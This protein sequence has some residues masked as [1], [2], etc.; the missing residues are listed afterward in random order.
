MKK[1]AFALS[2]LC[3]ALQSAGLAAQVQQDAVPDE[4][5]NALIVQQQDAAAQQAAA[6]K[7]KEVETIVVVG[8]SSTRQEDITGAAVDVNIAEVEDLSSA[9]IMQNLQ[10]RVPG[11][12][13]LTNGNPNSTAQ[14]KIRGQGLGPL[15]YNDPLYVVDGVPMNSG[16]HE[17]NSND[18]ASLV[19][20][21]DAASASIYGARAANGVIIITTKKGRGDARFEV[22]LNTSTEDFEYDLNPLNTKQRAEAVWRAAVNDGANPNNV[23]P[24][25]QYDWNGDFDNPQLNNVI[26]NTYID[27]A[28]TMRPA[29]TDWFD[30]V[31][32][33]S[34]SK[35]LNLSYSSGS[36]TSSLYASLGY[37]DRNGV[38]KSSEFT[39][40]SARVNSHIELFDGK[41]RVGENLALTEQKQNLVNDLAG[42]ILGLA[43]EQQSIVPIRTEDG[44]GWG[45]PTAGITD[46]DNPVRLLEMNKDN[47]NRFNKVLGNVYVEYQPLDDLTL[48]SNYGLSYGNFK[49]R[50]FTKAFQAGSLNFNDRLT[51][52][53][54]WNKTIVWSNT[55]EYKYLLNYDHMFTLLVGSETV[56]FDSEFFS[57]SGSG[58]ASQDRDYAFLQQATSGITANG[59]ADAWTLKS[60]FTKL[61]YDYDRKYLA[62]FTLRR[63]GSSRFG[64][65]NQWG[66]FPAASV[67]WRVSDEDF[68]KFDAMN[69]LKFRASWGQNGNQ[70]INT[71]ATSSIFQSRYATQSLFTNEQDEGT[72]YDLTGSDQG[73]LPS[74]FAKVSSGNPDLKWETSTQLNLGVDFDFFDS[75]LYGSF[76]WFRKRTEDILTTTQP[77]AT[78]GEGAQ[79]IV[80]G[81]TIENTGI[82]LMLG[83]TDEF[84]LA[85]L[86]NFTFDITGNISTAKNKVV[87]LPDSVV[88]SFGGNGQDK[89]ILGKSVNSV[90]GYVTD[91]L[92]QSAEEVAA[93][94]S[95]PGAA[96]GRIRYVDLN[97]DGVIND[98][99]QDFFTNTDPDFIYGLNFTL[100]YG[101]WDFNMFW[102]G[103]KGGSVR[104]SWRLFTDF[105]SLNIGSNYGDRT[106]NAWTPDNTGSNVPALTLLDN[107]NEARE[108]SF[109]WEDGS[110]LKLRNLSIAYNIDPNILDARVYL[111]AQNLLTITPSGTL[112]QDPEAPN[113]VFPIPRTLTLGLSMTF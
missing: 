48:R 106:L 20:L 62:S 71:R 74:G 70:E 34:T 38:V 7:E 49:F 58:F 99:D 112:S 87:A 25:Y 86:G 65:N 11:V 76:D 75:A 45:G 78:E 96:P 17:I 98:Q 68:F 5:P 26:L 95:Q 90:F 22:K 61:D 105:T 72:A 9:N 4:L 91:G 92:F 54:D 43:I 110:Y 46:R 108:S 40:L 8:Y 97:N 63:D 30:E 111:S 64:Q 39:R 23:S 88:N 55:A 14:V 36:D 53:D 3:C 82:E 104:N 103:V 89:T 107:N 85:S 32:R 29:D 109:Y 24:L 57:A 113:S 31:T 42:G 19:V 47:T 50:N 77:L 6:D 93:H 80:N 13:I 84:T 52:T 66:N 35:D 81:G 41:V 67:G 28:Q 100:T 16:M 51:V 73:N 60:Y 101:R 56:E 2:A 37:V 94:A 102:Q 18:I 79:M 12:Q 15:G 21:R 59:F 10:G 69:Q 1:Q 33:R 83:Y 44:T 27:S